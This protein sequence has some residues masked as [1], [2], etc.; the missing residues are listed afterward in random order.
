MVLKLGKFIGRG[1]DRACYENPQNP[2][3]CFKV[4]SVEH[5]RQTLREASYFK[6]LKKKGVEPSFMPKFY[7]FWREDDN[8]IIEQEYI[9]PGQDESVV[10]LSSYVRNSTDQELEELQERLNLVKE[11]MIALNVIV[12]DMRPMN[13]FVVKTVKGIK[14][15]VIFDGYGTPEFL[16]LPN[17]CRFFGKKK[18]ERQ[19]KKFLRYFSAELSKRVSSDKN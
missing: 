5:S 15:I 4:S 13:F 11:E 3:T 14:R 6:Y 19:W 12:S 18:I 8:F 9:H 7:K 17:Y 10:D 1:M 16:P 2:N